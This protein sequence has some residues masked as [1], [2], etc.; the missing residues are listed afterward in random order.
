[1]PPRRRKTAVQ[2]YDLIDGLMNATGQIGVLL[3]GVGAL[4]KCLGCVITVHYDVF[5]GVESSTVIKVDGLQT[6]V[7]SK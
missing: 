3:G 2:T 4:L 7:V 1:M 6:T 5:V